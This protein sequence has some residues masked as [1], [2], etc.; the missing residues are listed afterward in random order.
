MRRP[1]SVSLAIASRSMSPVAMCGI[2]TSAEM[3]FA[4][5][6]LPAPGGP[7][8]TTSRATGRLL[9]ES[10]VVAHHRLRLHLTHGVERDAHHDEDRGAPE[11]T[12]CCLREAAVAD[13]KSRQGRDEREVERTGEREPRQHPVEVLRWRR[14]TPCAGEVAAVLPQVVGLVDRVELNGRVEVREDHDQECL[15]DQV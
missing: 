8:M 5:V 7:R 14:G 6:P 11:G 12:V 15:Q 2:P 3:R 4:W 10:L 9:Q 13:E 1:I